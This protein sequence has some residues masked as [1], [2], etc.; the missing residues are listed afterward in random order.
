MTRVK[1]T[2]RIHVAVVYGGRSSEHSVSCVSAG[3]IMSH[4]D[5]ERY[6]VIPVGITQDGT[7][8]VGEHNPERLRIDGRT[9]PTVTGGQALTLAIDPA[10]KGEFRYADGPQV[11]ELYATADVI[12]PVL[13]GR[14]GEDGTIQGLFELSGVPYV[15]TGVLSSAAG[16]DKEA[17]KKLFQAEG[18]PIGVDVVM[19]GR[20]ELTEA[21]KDLLG[22]PVFVKPACGGSSIGISKVSSWE[23][24]PQAVNLAREHDHKVIVESEILGAEIEVGVLQKPTGEVVASV[25]AQLVGTDASEEGFYGFD[26]KYLEDVVAAHIPAPL[27]EHHIEHIRSLA[28]EAFHALN[29]EGIAR[30]DFFMTAAGPVLNEINTMPGF[31][32]ISMY[33]QVFAASGIDYA[34]LLGLLIERALVTHGPKD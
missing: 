28:V 8:V 5:P 19:R 24:F 1:N 13:H 29:C 21:E 30:V 9:L 31:T 22:L 34:D 25:P 17:T 2:D 16:Q 32:P 12:F 11:G 3:A 26:T 23:D 33:P 15:G 7:W 14:F 27:P 10:H 6:H 4:L 18:L 20:T